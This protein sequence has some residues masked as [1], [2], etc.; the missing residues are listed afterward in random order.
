MS[1]EEL[2][3]YIEEEDIVS[4]MDKKLLVG[5]TKVFEITGGK[6]VNNDIA[7]EL[8]AKGESPVLLRIPVSMR[9]QIIKRFGNDPRNWNG[10]FIELK[11]EEFVPKEG[12]TNVSPG[13]ST[14]LLDETQ[15]EEEHISSSK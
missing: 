1:L 5:Q 13:V 10:N 4:W 11:F 9:N 2:G 15:V 7:L 6:K 3:T 8:T 14:V 12:Q